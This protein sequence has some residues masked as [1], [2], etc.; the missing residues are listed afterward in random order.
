MGYEVLS[1][2]AKRRISESHRMANHN[3]E[4][5]THNLIIVFVLLFFIVE[6]VGCIIGPMIFLLC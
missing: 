4:L 2:R 5:I 3:S 1:S 6:I